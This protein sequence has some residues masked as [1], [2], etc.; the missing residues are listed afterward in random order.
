MDRRYG[1]RRNS[2]EAVFKWR[3]WMQKKDMK[4]VADQCINILKTLNYHIWVFYS[5]CTRYLCLGS[6]CV[7]FKS[8]D[9]FDTALETLIWLF[10]LSILN[11]N[12]RMYWQL[13]VILF[14]E[15]L[16]SALI[17]SETYRWQD[18]KNLVS[19]RFAT[20]YKGLHRV[21]LL[22]ILCVCHFANKIIDILFI[23]YSLVTPHCLYFKSVLKL[24]T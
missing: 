6:Y 14:S 4:A 17:L 12:K 11:H 21:A 22:T 16:I 1:T 3:N 19:L 8:H 23:I 7:A 5:Y 24:S 10:W 9:I 15:C 2:K 18:H 20:W 13:Y